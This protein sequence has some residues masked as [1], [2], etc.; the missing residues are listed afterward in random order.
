MVFFIIHF[1]SELMMPFDAF[2]RS[3]TYLN[4]CSLFHTCPSMI[5]SLILFIKVTEFI[6]SFSEKVIFFLIPIT[7][8]KVH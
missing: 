5:I 1:E 7:L 2:S 3:L 6:Y 4:K 8:T